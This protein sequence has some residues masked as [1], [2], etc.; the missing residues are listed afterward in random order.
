MSD[1]PRLPASWRIGPDHV[2]RLDA[3]VIIGI[4]NRT[5]D[6]FYADSRH[7]STTA[8][9]EQAARMAQAGAGVLD[10][11]GESTRPGAARIPVD[12][13][14]ARVIPT[15]QAIR[16]AGVNLPISIDTTRL[17]VARA[18]LDA[19]A[20]II[21]DV[22]AGEESEDR[23]FTLAAERSAGLILMHR[24]RPPDTD[25]F[26][27]AYASA[28]VY[29]DG[30]VHTVCAYL[31]ARAEA[32]LRAGV[33]QE[34]IVLDPGL[35]FGKTV[36][37]NHKLIRRIDEVAALGYPVLCAV[38]RKS[39]VGI[40]HST[41]TSLPVADRLS[42]SIAIAQ[43]M[44]RTGLRLFRVHDVADHVAAL[45]DVPGDSPQP[46][47]GNNPASTRVCEP[48]RGK[49]ARPPTGR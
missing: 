44:Q 5:P 48:G 9:S 23:I 10:L 43:T 8:A 47:H 38:S 24:L 11:G 39:F 17:D 30:V 42:G 7:A 19:G 13:Q 46:G 35:G 29:T 15:I 2:I 20:N 34:A 6:S 33:S 41:E 25:A 4:I 16:A 40:A 37:Q 32:A 21:N 27:N 22:S 14:I 18:A 45:S 49:L 1:L 31:Q 28:P 12:E 26:S 36:E 3:P